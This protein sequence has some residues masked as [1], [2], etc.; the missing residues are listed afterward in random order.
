MNQLNMIDTLQVSEDLADSQDAH[1][2]SDLLLLEGETLAL[3][4]G[5]SIIVSW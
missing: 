5:G 2:S 4:G 1:A 3:A